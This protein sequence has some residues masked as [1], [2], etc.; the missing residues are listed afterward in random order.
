M[1]LRLSHGT[2][3]MV[4]LPGEP[5]K[6]K[7][8]MISLPWKS[9]LASYERGIHYVAI[10]ELQLCVWMLTESICGQLAWTLAYDVSLDP[11]CHMLW[12]LTMEPRWDIL[13]SK[14]PYNMDDYY[15]DDNNDDNDNYND[16]DADD[17]DDDDDNTDP[18]D[19]DKVAGYGYG[20]SWD[21]NGEEDG[22]MLGNSWNSDTDNFINLDKDATLLDPPT[23]RVYCEILGFH[24]YKN[25]L[26]LLVA[27]KVVVYH[28][29]TSRM[30]YLG[31]EYAVS[32]GPVQHARS[33]N[34]SFTYRPCYEDVL[35]VGKFYV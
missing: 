33:L 8:M 15:E 32:Q 27:R 26:V 11:Y 2:Y 24:P 25:A 31:D 30:Q 4:Q 18:D 17:D 7:C 14:V 34:G 23:R 12:N 21:F 6:P 22:Y 13:A 1:V 28:L 3:D 5:G 20:Y 10:K 29:N 19:D 9:V 16:D 35:P